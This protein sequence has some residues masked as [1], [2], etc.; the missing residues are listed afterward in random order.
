MEREIDLAPQEK[1][2]LKMSNLIKVKD[3]IG[4]TNAK[5]PESFLTINA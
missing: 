3:L 1:F 2:T 5:E 4:D